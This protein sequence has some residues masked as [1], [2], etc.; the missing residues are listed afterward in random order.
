L[1]PACGR[2]S[3]FG[4]EPCLSAG[5]YGDDYLSS[6]FWAWDDDRIIG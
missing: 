4:R 5:S 2:A 3:P 1:P 6:P